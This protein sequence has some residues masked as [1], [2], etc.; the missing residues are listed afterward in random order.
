MYMYIYIYIY[1][2]AH[3]WI[4]A[5]IKAY[6][7]T[8][9]CIYIYIYISISTYIYAQFIYSCAQIFTRRYDDFVKICAPSTIDALT[10]SAKAATGLDKSVSFFLWQHLYRSNIP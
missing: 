1:A 7:D 5:Y 10:G 2:V 8:H 9:I 3:L 6:V 4:A